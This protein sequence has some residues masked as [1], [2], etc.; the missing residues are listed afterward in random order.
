MIAASEIIHLKIN[1]NTVNVKTALVKQNDEILV[2]IFEIAD[3]LG[4]EAHFDQQNI[5]SLNHKASLHK[6]VAALEGV[7]IKLL[8]RR[9]QGFLRDF[10]LKIGDIPV[11]FPEWVNIDLLDYYPKL[12][13]LDLNHDGQEEIAVIL[14]IKKGN[15]L[16][17]N[18]VHTFAKSADV[19]NPVH[20]IFHENLQAEIQKNTSFSYT[21]THLIINLDEKEKIYIPKTDLISNDENIKLSLEHFVLYKIS[22]Q[23]LKGVLLVEQSNRKYIGSII[24]TYRYDNNVMM[25]DDLEFKRH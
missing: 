3:R 15:G 5:L 19:N 1:Q 25:I 18:K 9:D 23:K 16:F 8:A 11:E 7:N 10:V 4:I 17:V 6:E 13:S 14:T 21:K 22:K 24:A 20:E 2:P 12:Y